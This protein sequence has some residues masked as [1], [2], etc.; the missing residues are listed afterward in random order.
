MFKAPYPPYDPTDKN[1]FS[2]E[3]VYK[4]WPIILT[5]IIDH[6]HRLNHDCAMEMQQD[7]AD[8]KR[9]E[10]DVRVQASKDIIGTISKLKYQM[11]RDH[12]LELIPS[13]NEPFVELYNTELAELSQSNKDTWFTAPWL[14]AECYLYRLLRSWFT[15][16]PS[17]FWQSFDPFFGQKMDTLK[18]SGDAI[19]QLAT[20]L[21]EVSE[22]KD[23]LESDPDKLGVLFKEMVQ[24]CLW[25]NATDLSLLTNPSHADIQDLQSVGRDAQEKRKD[26]ILRDDQDTVWAHLKTLKGGRVDFALDNAGYELFTDFVFADFLVTYT[27]Y[28]SRV[29][30]HPKLIPWFVSDVTPPDFRALIESL[31]DPSFFPPS[32]RETAEQSKAHVEA[33]VS[34]WKRYID[35]GK[36]ALSVPA[37]TPLG[38]RGVTEGDVVKKG[39]FWTQPYAY[40]DMKERATELWEELA[41][42]SGLVIFKGDLHY[43]KLTG[44]VRWPAFTPWE[45]AIGPLAGSFP[46]LSLR[47]SKADVVAGVNGEVADKLDQEQGNKWRVN[48]KYALISFCPAKKQT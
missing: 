13:D 20:T 4:R 40:W 25:G 17:M 7:I 5:G 33:M 31:S 9:A 30:F 24:M 39:G 26:F 14:Y 41:K 37:D 47:T 12:K 22:E 34:R 35:E 18:S 23:T 32:N 36:F 19:Y 11:A 6:L 3:T 8:D 27:P 28:V 29:V 16:S 1:C 2:Y 46:I 10:L 43:R 42:E 45:T 48:G 38:P 44:D 15:T 21:H